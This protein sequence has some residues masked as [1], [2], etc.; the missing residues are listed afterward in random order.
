MS[1]EAQLFYR[2]LHSVVDDFGR[3]E[4]DPSIL[5]ARCFARQLERWPEE[6]IAKCLA[7][8]SKTAMDD[9]LPLVFS[10][11]C[12]FKKYLEINKFN[13]RIRPETKSK[14]PPP[15]VREVVDFLRPADNPPQPAAI[16]GDPQEPAA[17]RARTPTPPQAPTAPTEVPESL[18]K[19]AC[20]SE[21][22]LTSQEIHKH[23]PA[24]DE[25]F[26][27]RLVQTTFQACI[28]DG[29]IGQEEIEAI[30]DEWLAK[31]VRTS[32]AKFTGKN[33]HGT[34]LLLN[35]VPQIIMTWCKEDVA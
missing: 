11:E 21:Y 25:M 17:T 27:L 22:P 19:L 10:Y 5:R 9:G 8:C 23:D 35:R 6:R 13:Q 20:S 24:C 34:G 18:P 1:E 31:A 3:Y 7:E 32:Y 26:V 28:S 29:K 14:F 2:C 15:S 4:A 33:G 30:N 16:G 12:D